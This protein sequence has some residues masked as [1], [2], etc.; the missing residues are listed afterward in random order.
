MRC[1]RRNFKK[2]ILNYKEMMTTKGQYLK[3]LSVTFTLILLYT[4]LL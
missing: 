1:G 4:K 2:F 3:N